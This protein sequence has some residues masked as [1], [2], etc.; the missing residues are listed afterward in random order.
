MVYTLT[1]FVLRLTSPPI[2][3][4]IQIYLQFTTMKKGTVVTVREKPLLYHIVLAG[5]LGTC[6]R[7]R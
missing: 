7:E 2:S 6:G 1:L 4:G 5:T 3:S